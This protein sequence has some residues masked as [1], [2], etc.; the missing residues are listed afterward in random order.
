[1]TP[2]PSRPAHPR[3]A[4]ASPSSLPSPPRPSRPAHP[5]PAPA[6][7]SSLPFTP[8]P[9]LVA[10]IALVL[11]LG[12]GACGRKGSPVP[13]GT[14][15]PLPVSEFTGFIEE[16]GS[17]HLAW[18]NPHR[19]LDNARLRDLVIER[20]YRVADQGVGEPKPA[21]LSRGRVAGYTELFTIRFPP[22]RTSA[23]VIPPPPPP[24]P[25]GV[26]VDGDRVRVTDREG[27]TVGHRYTYVVIAQD[28]VGRES[29][30]SARVS[31]TMIPAA[32]PPTAPIV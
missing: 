10:L 12:L 30:P 1:M 24:L 9:S 18:R 4:P 28:S 22:P 14:R 13:P 19:R 3:P 15:V 8:P 7:P 16:D 20:L 26:V 27:L 21:L 23:S 17:I 5:R 29:A 6:S 31:L 25:P 11:L 2:R 32:A